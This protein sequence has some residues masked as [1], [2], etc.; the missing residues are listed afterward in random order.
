MLSAGLQHARPFRQLAEVVRQQA[1]EGLV[2]RRGH[3]GEGYAESERT[4]NSDLDTR[5]DTVNGTTLAGHEASQEES[6]NELERRHNGLPLMPTGDHRGGRPALR[7]QLSAD[8]ASLPTDHWR[9]ERRG[10][11]PAERPCPF[12]G[13][14]HHLLI[15]SISE[16][17]KIRFN[18]AGGGDGDA[19]DALLRLPHSCSLDVADRSPEALH[20]REASGSGWAVT[21][22]TSHATLQTVGAALGVTGEMVRQIEARAMGRAKCELQHRG[23]TAQRLLAE[24][25]WLDDAGDEQ[26]P[27]WATRQRRAA[28]VAT[29][30]SPGN[31]AEPFD[32]RLALDGMRFRAAPEAVETT[33][34]TEE[35]T[36]SETTITLPTEVR[37]CQAPGC[38]HEVK[39]G[40]KVCSSQCAGLLAKAANRLDAECAT[41]GAAIKIMP[42]HR[43]CRNQC[44]ACKAAKKRPAKTAPQP[45]PE[46]PAVA[47]V[48]PVAQAPAQSIDGVLP[49]QQLAPKAKPMAG[50]LA[51]LQARCERTEAELLHRTWCLA[52]AERRLAEVKAG[53]ETF[54]VLVKRLRAELGETQSALGERTQQREQ[55]LLDLDDRTVQRDNA[56][57]QVGSYRAEIRTLKEEKDKLRQEVT[58]LRELAG[59]KPQPAAPLR[60]VLPDP[61]ALPFAYAVSVWQ[62]VSRSMAQAAA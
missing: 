19:V 23:M 43:D 53:N 52:D 44:D 42:M 7:A 59:E 58:G 1:G 33:E 39:P 55:A 20:P 34:T 51:E 36:M 24:V 50:E 27:A 10:E 29:Q 16:K 48:A 32:V 57:A 49:S 25:D 26:P 21:V 3:G 15:D 38:D 60:V 40:C 56:I 12:V 28:S 6:G 31:D 22:G 9:P 17:G 35:P 46:A 37:L 41:C 2:A 8:Y 14:R 4:V 62:V 61:E 30:G 45:Q 5:I 11:C 13:C 47:P 18:R 54:L